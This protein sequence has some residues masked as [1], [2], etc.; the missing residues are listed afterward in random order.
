MTLNPN[1]IVTLATF[2][3]NPNLKWQVFRVTEKPTEFLKKTEN[4]EIR[5]KHVFLGLQKK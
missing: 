2:I 1:L 5:G 4:T 3:F